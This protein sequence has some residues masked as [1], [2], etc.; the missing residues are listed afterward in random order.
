MDDR[1]R[2]STLEPRIINSSTR[3]ETFIEEGC[4]ITEVWNTPQDPTLSIARARVAP[5]TKTEWH[6]LEVDE[7]YLVSEGSGIMEI[8]GEP[9]VAVNPG[10]VIAVPLGLGQRIRNETDHE[11]IFYCLCTPRFEP[12]VYHPWRGPGS[13]KKL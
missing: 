13:D 1:P 6:Y 7:R 12:A 3:Q 10:D 4:F 11:L 9:P 5:H 8:E 2:L